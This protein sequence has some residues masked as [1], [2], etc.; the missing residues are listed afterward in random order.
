MMTKPVVLTIL[1]GWGIAPATHGNAVTQAHTPNF[2]RLWG[3][4]G[5]AKLTTF[6][7]NVGLPDGQ[8][9]NSEVGHL[10]IGAGR[11]VFQDLPRI[12]KAAAGTELAERIA[13][14]G[15]ID[16]LKA[17]G[18][19]CHLAGLVSDGGVH[20]HQEHA[21]AIAHILAQA[22]ISVA[23]H[24]FSDG[25]DTAPSSAAGFLADVEAR[26]PASARIATVSG[27]YYA[28]DRDKRWERIE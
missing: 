15:S 21:L 3:E 4:W 13:T 1:D 24:A 20:A 2:D 16:A 10:N 28:M 17:S 25:R 6:G 9:G 7:P 5:H 19:T 22:G 8:M 23:L 26:L 12:N 18:G 27:R 14:S 11:I